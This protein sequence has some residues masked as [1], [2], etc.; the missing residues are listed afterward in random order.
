MSSSNYV[1]I[2]KNYILFNY[3][4]N[5]YCKEIKKGIK[6]GIIHNRNA[7]IKEFKSILKENKIFPFLISKKVYIM[8]PFY[9]SANDLNELKKAFLD[10]GYLYIKISK[11]SSIIKMNKKDVYLCNDQLLYV[12]KYNIKR[13]MLLDNLL[14]DKEKID[15]IK[16][17]C[18]NKD[19][20]IISSDL[21]IEKE[22]F[23]YYYL[24]NS[25]LLKSLK[26]SFKE[27]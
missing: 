24:P 26:M 27:V 20:Y 16:K 12:D 6:N 19:L 2:D 18:F 15:I 25:F 3:K 13:C 17:R 22:K 10:L 7:F 8:C 21:K 14:T 5:I 9:L 4:K 11:I 1:C 23:D